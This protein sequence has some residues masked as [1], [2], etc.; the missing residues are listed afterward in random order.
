M[1]V[2]LVEKEMLV[3]WSDGMEIGDFDKRKNV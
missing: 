2:K 1:K 3:S